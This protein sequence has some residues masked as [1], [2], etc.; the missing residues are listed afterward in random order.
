[1]EPRKFRVAGRDF[2]LTYPK[3]PV[4]PEEAVNFFRGL[5]GKKP[6]YIAVSKEAHEDGT[7][8]LHAQLQFTKIFNM[9]VCNTFDMPWQ[10]ENYHPNIKRTDSSE[11]WRD[12]IAKVNEPLTYGKFRILHIAKNSNERRDTKLVNERIINEDL[13]ELVKEGFISM[14]NYTQL[15]NA[16]RQ[17]IMDSQQPPAIFPRTCYWIYG[18]P[19]IGKSYWV[20]SKFPNAYCKPQ[21]KWWDGYMSQTEVLMDDFDCE[22]LGHMLKIWADSYSFVAEVKGN[23]VS[24]V[25]TKLFLTSN[26]LPENIFKDKM[27]A[28]AVTRRFRLC[29]IENYELVDLFTNEKIII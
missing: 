16:K 1:M 21:N 6:S 24:P 15:S 14:Y 7:P 3:C 29:T 5:L 27:V 4:P 23:S 17:F 25:Y 2:A 20:R 12:Y 19:G 11:N 22:V 18:E 10:G 8:H 13:T 28:A 26:Y 9:T